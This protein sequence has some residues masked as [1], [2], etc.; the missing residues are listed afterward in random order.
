MISKSKKYLIF[1]LKW[2]KLK[3]NVLNSLTI[4][5]FQIIRNRIIIL[6]GEN[7][8]I[9]KKKSLSNLTIPTKK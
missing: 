2:T 8:Y 1:S 5:F 9:E 4:N 6:V 7:I 3:E